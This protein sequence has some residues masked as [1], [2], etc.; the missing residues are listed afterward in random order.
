[1]RAASPLDSIRGVFHEVARKDDVEVEKVSV[2]EYRRVLDDWR[3]LTVSEPPVYRK[4]KIRS[5]RERVFENLDPL[6][7]CNVV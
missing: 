7:A 5:I 2:V 1:M 4:I 6:G 3:L